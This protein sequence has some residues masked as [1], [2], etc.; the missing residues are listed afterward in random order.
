VRKRSA[1]V[2]AVALTCLTAAAVASMPAQ[3]RGDLDSRLRAFGVP[4]GVVVV[5]AQANADGDFLT[6]VY[7]DDQGESHQIGGIVRHET[8]PPE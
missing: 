1:V 3:S 6:V 7:K 2:T 5:A 4:E 8:P